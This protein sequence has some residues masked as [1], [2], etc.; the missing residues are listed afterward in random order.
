ML[1]FLINHFL[2]LCK[3]NMSLSQRVLK[4][5]VCGGDHLRLQCLVL[6]NSCSGD[7]RNC[8]CQSQPPPQKKRTTQKSRNAPSRS[9]DPEPDYEKLYSKLVQ[10]H[11]RVRKAFQALQTQHEQLGTDLEEKNQ[12]IEE[13]DNDAQELADLVKTKEKVTGELK[14]PWLRPKIAFQ[15]WRRKSVAYRRIGLKQ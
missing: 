2:Q 3:S 7:K 11:E 1:M 4:C 12:E 9:D 15:H 6:C 8:D 13:L 10:C 14:T 5:T